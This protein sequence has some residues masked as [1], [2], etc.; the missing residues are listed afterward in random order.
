V[1]ASA[2][3]HREA[4]IAFGEH[5]RKIGARDQ[6]RLSTIARHERAGKLAQLVRLCILAAPLDEV[7]VDVLDP[8]DFPGRG[9][10]VSMPSREPNMRVSMVKRVPSNA[11]RFKPC[12]FTAARTSV[13]ILI[14]GNEEIASSCEAQM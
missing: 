11:T 8:L 1:N 7:L 6:Y 3:D 5:G 13:S 4:G 10:I 2:I 14:S 12:A 9:M